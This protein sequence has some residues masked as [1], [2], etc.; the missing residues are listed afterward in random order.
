[1]TCVECQQGYLGVNCSKMCPFPTF[2]NKCSKNCT[3]E[4]E[5][6][7]FQIGC[8][9]VLTNT[10][11]DTRNTDNTK[12]PQGSIDKGNFIDTSTHTHEDTKSTN[13]TKEPQGAIDKGNFIDTSIHYTFL[14]I[15]ASVFSVV[16]IAYILLLF[17][18]KQRKKILRE[19]IARQI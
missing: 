19:W 14:L 6:C 18:D 3:C 2:G 17:I 12:E 13:N 7:N 16:L 8:K 10:H 11:E 1:M 4:K 15:G 9:K 5:M